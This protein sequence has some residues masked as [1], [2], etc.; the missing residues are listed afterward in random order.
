MSNVTS[1]VNAAIRDDM[2]SAAQRAACL[3]LQHR[4]TSP[5]NSAFTLCT[6]Y[7]KKQ[8]ISLAD[9]LQQH[10]TKTSIRAQIH[11]T[12]VETNPGGWGYYQDEVRSCAKLLSC[13][14]IYPDNVE[15][16]L[17][18]TAVDTVSEQRSEPIR[19]WNIPRWMVF[20]SLFTFDF[21]FN[22]WQIPLNRKKHLSSDI[23]LEERKVVIWHQLCWGEFVLLYS[24]R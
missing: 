4:N 13:I 15:T 14:Q 6:W 19:K 7:C 12:G 5:S 8:C 23:R 11:L 16:Q 24:R 17:R 20:A 3:I 22:K 21:I 9:E 1:C 18:L 10:A 2:I